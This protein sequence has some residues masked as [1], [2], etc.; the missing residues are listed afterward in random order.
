MKLPSISLCCV[1]GAFQAVKDGAVCALRSNTPFGAPDASK[2]RSGVSELYGR[3]ATDPGGEFHFH[4]GPEYAARQLGYDPA[5]LAALPRTST[6]S[7]AGAANPH[8]VAELQPGETVLDLGCG[9][10]TDLLIAA[11]KVGPNGRVIGVDMTQAMLDRCRNACAE[12]GLENVELKLGDAEQIPVEDASVD[13][14]ISNGVLN[15]VPDKTR[16][17]REI[18]RVLRPGGR[19]QHGDTVISLG[20]ARLMRG[21]VDLWTSCVGGALQERELVQ[22]VTQVGFENARV[23]QR[24]DCARGTPHE[25]VARLLGVHGM[26][27]AAAKPALAHVQATPDRPTAER[28]RV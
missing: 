14:V 17:F 1:A 8:A 5:E 18:Y 10:G 12:M 6:E 20:V 21:S 3:V 22:L 2:V 28:V 26:N 23:T 25:K 24:Y 27:L 16:A 15:L 7:F 4:R 19:L 11:R 9:A 13:V